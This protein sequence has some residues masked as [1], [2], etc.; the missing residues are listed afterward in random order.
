MFANAKA[1]LTSRPVLMPDPM[2][3]QLA[4]SFFFYLLP[5]KLLLSDSAAQTEWFR[6]PLNTS[7]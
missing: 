6:V 5:V 4:I 7:Q 2:H 1:E 3:L